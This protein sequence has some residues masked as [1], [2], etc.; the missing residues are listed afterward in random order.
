MTKLAD[1]TKRSA[2][3]TFTQGG[4]ASRIADTPDGLRCQ[5]QDGDDAPWNGTAGQIDAEVAQTLTGFVIP[6]GAERWVR[7]VIRYDA[8]A[9]EPTGD[10][11][12]PFETHL[13]AGGTSAPWA[14]NL[15]GQTHQFCYT[16]QGWA[17]QFPGKAQ[18]PVVPGET[19]TM[20][21][22]LLPHVSAGWFQ[23]WYDGVKAWEVSGVRTIAVA[24]PQQM[25]VGWYRPK[26][27][28]GLDSVTY[29]EISLHDSRPA[30]EAPAPPPVEQPTPPAEPGTT[31]TAAQIQGMRDAAE[32]IRGNARTLMNKERVTDADR[33]RRATA[34][35][36]KAEAILD[37]L[38]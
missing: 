31:Y 20:D 3:A 16:P 37:V 25:K 1:Y 22:G 13:S 35:N 8:V 5:C 19:F 34:M 21:V 38:D 4:P 10:W 32:V 12:F 26:R 14:I 36:A 6:Y 33:K 18:R 29:R 28:S 30:F 24:E 7:L 2:W 9:D 17:R 11:H 27:V 15:K 23:V